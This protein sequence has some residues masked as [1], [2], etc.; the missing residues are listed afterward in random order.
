MQATM[1][2]RRISFGRRAG[3]T[4]VE[5]LVVIAIIAM[6]VTLLLPAV[7]SARAAA[8]R[9]HCSNNIKQLALA[10]HNMETTFGVLPPFSAQN[11][12]AE[13]TV[14]GPYKGVVGFT[15]FNWMLPYIEEQSL[16]DQCVKERGFTRSEP[17]S[18]NHEAVTGYLCPSEPNRTGPKGE[19]RG[20][21]DGIGGPTNWG[22][23]NYAANYLVFGNPRKMDVE[24]STK[25]SQIPDG[26]SKTVIFGERYANCTNVGHLRTGVYTSLWSDATSFW[27]PVFCINNLS[28]SPTTEGYPPCGKFQVAPNFK[29]SCDASRAQSPHA[30]GMHCGNADGSV[31]LFS[32]DIEADAWARL[33]DPRDQGLSLTV[34]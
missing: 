17:G 24:G 30:A 3:F 33:C 29:D 14:D 25:F 16:Y 19:G 13:V 10:I 26:L 12:N 2:T 32:G 27:R 28:R 7:Q 21:V 23:S 18:P 15:V 4:L 5:L 20:L 34:K 31:K 9:T 11:Q 6:L 22:V 8:R 1:R